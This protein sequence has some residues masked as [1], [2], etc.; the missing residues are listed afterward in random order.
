M[1]NLLSYL[2]GKIPDE[3][4]F[5]LALRLVGGIRRMHKDGSEEPYNVTELAYVVLESCDD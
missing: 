3:E 1:I 5:P 2:D 4:L